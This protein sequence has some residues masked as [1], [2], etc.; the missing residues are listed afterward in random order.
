MNI[1]VDTIRVKHIV[2][3]ISLLAIIFFF[4]PTFFVSCSGERKEMSAFDLVKGITYEGENMSDAHYIYVLLIVLP[5]VIAV[6]W[7]VPIAISK[8]AKYATT[9]CVT[10]GDI[11]VWFVL[12][13]QFTSSAKDLMKSGKDFGDSSRQFSQ[14]M[15]MADSLLKTGTT[16]WFW[17]NMLLLV[18]LLILG[19]MLFFGKTLEDAS[20]LALQKNVADVTSA[21]TK[22]VVEMTNVAAQHVQNATQT[23]AGWTCENCQAVNSPTAK[24]CTQCGTAK[25]VV[26]EPEPV[27]E[28]TPAEEVKEEVVEETK[29]DGRTC[30]QCGAEV[31]ETA[32]FCTKCGA[33]L[34]TEE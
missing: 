1:S 15:G 4:V 32:K 29:P 28:E 16:F 9:A 25:P 27:V 34:P 14:M 23:K 19:A 33:Q 2:K 13:A 17:V 5:I 21:A 30:P 7:F 26:V 6:L 10:L 31:S 24:F 22:N 8:A 18:V 20:V 3:T 12:K 11:V